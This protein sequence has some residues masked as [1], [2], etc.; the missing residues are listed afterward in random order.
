MLINLFYVIILI[1]VVVALTVVFLYNSLIRLTNQAKNAW[2]NIDVQLRRR[3]DLI[4]NLVET[5]KGYAKHE[6]EVFEQVTKARANAMQAQGIAAQSQAENLLTRA[7]GQLRVVAEAYPDLKASQNFL[8]LQEE[9]AS[10]ENK[11]AFARQFYNDSAMRL[12][13]K[14]QSFPTNIIAQLFGFQPLEYFQIED[15]N[16]RNAPSTNFG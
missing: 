14:L 1:A 7:L 9:L 13:T 2:S 5:V 11:I 12:N 15:A 8:A 6:R 16:A 4:P 10:T 3:H